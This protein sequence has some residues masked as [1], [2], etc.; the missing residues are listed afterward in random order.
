LPN[1]Y[2]WQATDEQAICASQLGRHDEAFTLFRRLL[3]R[4]DVS[5]NDRRR[6]AN[7]RDFSVPTMLEAASSYPDL[8]VGG[9]VAGPRDAEVTVS[10][11]AGPDRAATEQTLNSFLHCCTDVSRVGRFLVIDAGL[12]VQDRE[13][14]HG[15]YGFLEFADCGPSDGPGAQLAHVRAQIGGRFWLHLGQGWRFFAPE[16]FI[17]RLT[18]V[19]DAEAQVC[20]VGINL[21]G[22]AKLTGACAAEET[23]RRAPDAGRYVLTDVITSGPA[24]FNTARLDRAGGID[25]T[26]VNPIAALR[27]RAAAAGLHTASLDEVLCITAV[28]QVQQPAQSIYYENLVEH[29]DRTVEL[30]QGVS[31]E[32]IFNADYLENDLIPAL[33]LNNENLWE[34]PE[35]LAPYFGTG[36]HLWQYPNQFSRYLVWLA[37]NASNIRS[38][39]EIGCRWGGTFILV[40]EWLKR[41]GATLDVLVAVDPIPPTPFIARYMEI[42]DTPVIY[43]ERFSTD[44][45]F[46]SFFNELRPEMVFIDGDHSMK[47][48]INDHLLVRKTAKIIVHHDISSH[49]CPTTTLFWKYVSTAEDEFTATAFTDQYATVKGEFLGVGAMI[50]K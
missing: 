29:V 42:S 30:I 15:L 8:V 32:T 10:L 20:Q 46:I 34:Q 36:L 23:V 3:A 4:P 38:Y 21:A 33:G 48:V 22:A 9:L 13:K 11:V 28:H 18:A 17:T 43:Q 47:G 35:E 39:M 19:L 5:D 6:F 31:D 7:N 45:S 16:N 49:A 26:D 41:I 14:L 44:P 27:R 50:R 37:R 24:M 2:G 25:D 40:S 1:V 12:S